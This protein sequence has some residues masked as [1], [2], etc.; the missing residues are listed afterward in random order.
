MRLFRFSA[1]AGS[2]ILIAHICRFSDNHALAAP[3]DKVAGSDI[4]E[5][6][7]SAAGRSTR[8]VRPEER[9]GQKQVSEYSSGD[10]VVEGI[11]FHSDIGK[12]SAYIRLR[13]SGHGKVLHVGDGVGPFRLSVIE[14]SSVTL[15]HVNRILI[16]EIDRVELE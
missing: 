11:V 3:T 12:R 9:G 5:L 1:I 16:L 13:D 6:P 10:F 15:Y 2:I 4:K 14:D 8:P 7:G